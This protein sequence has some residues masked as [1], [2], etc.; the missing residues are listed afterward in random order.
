MIDL[1]FVVLLLAL[2]GATAA[3]VRV[4][5]RIIGSD[6]EAFTSEPADAAA[7]QPKLAA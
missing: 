1:V 5:D 6:E 7:E 3:F 4:C 2:F